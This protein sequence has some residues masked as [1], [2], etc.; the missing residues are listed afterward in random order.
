MVLA[1]LCRPL[2][3][4]SGVLLF[5]G[6]LLTGLNMLL[7]G[8]SVYAIGYVAL[9]LALLAIAA[10]NRERMDGWSWAGLAVLLV[11]LAMGLSSV[12]TIW[13]NY[14]RTG[15]AGAPMLLPVDAAPLGYAAEL[16]TWV[17]LASFALAARGAKVLAG[18][19]AWVS[20]AAS[21]IGLLAATRLLAPLW[22]VAAM[23]IVALVVLWM[24]SAMTA[25]AGTAE[26]DA[27]S[28]GSPPGRTKSAA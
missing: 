10:L 18:P 12:A 3:L 9:V 15:L 7:L 24:G 2:L 28:E 13:G 1:R 5:A 11:G 14:A 22:W 19:I 26:P 17:G 25:H 4:A 27:E 23:M 8:W 6:L 21:V 20:V 16:V